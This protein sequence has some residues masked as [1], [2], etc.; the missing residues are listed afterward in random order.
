M[1]NI[2]YG[3]YEEAWNGFAT[4]LTD[5]IGKYH[6]RNIC[7]I[8]GGANPVLGTDYI[9]EK[10]IDYYLL[11]I[12]EN[13]LNK[14]PENYNK[15]L[16]DIA[17]PHFNLKTKFDLIFTK[18]L[19]EHITDP[20]QFHKNVLNSLNTNGIA[21]HY[22]PT[23]Y[24]VPFFVNYVMPE[25]LADILLHMFESRDRFQHAK[26]PAYYR[27]CRGPTNKQIQRFI[28]LGY[29]VVEYRGFFGHPYYS[30][31]KVLDKLNSNKT[32]FH[33]K[34]PNPVFTSYAYVV[35]RKP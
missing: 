3:T 34:H 4:F 12:S 26:F 28:S 19:A 29:D 17:S 16:A 14:A 18:M 11:D 24:T 27:W 2:T 9:K 21:L 25:R 8:G 22:F 10:N 31:I 32:N 23:L 7:D 30:K 33:L 15:I 35:L 20:K 13:E 5:L 1:T 6:I